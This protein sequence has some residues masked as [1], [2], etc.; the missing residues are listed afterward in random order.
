VTDKPTPLAVFEHFPKDAAITAGVAGA[1]LYIL[2]RLVPVTIYSTPYLHLRFKSEREYPASVPRT[3]I[4]FYP[5][6]QSIPTDDIQVWALNVIKVEHFI[7]AGICLVSSDKADNHFRRIGAF[8][9]ECSSRSSE[10][11]YKHGSVQSLVLV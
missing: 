2:G 3:E 1:A 9:T 11:L 7:T 5:D 10:L 6:I 4:L 8:H